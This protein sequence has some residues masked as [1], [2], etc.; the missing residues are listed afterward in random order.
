MALKELRAELNL[1]QQQIAKI[2]NV[3]QQ[4]VSRLESGEVEMRVSQLGKLIKAYNLTMDHY[5]S[6]I[7]DQT[8]NAKPQ[9]IRK[10]G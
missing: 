4:Q 2:L 6:L 1:S 9:R 5:M 10:K 7:N 8:V 3:S